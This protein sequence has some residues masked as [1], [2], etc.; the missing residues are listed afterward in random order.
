MCTDWQMCVILMSHIY[1]LV[2]VCT[3]NGIQYDIGD[4]MQPNCTTRCTC[5]EGGNFVCTPQRCLLDGPTCYA[6]GD[7][8]YGSFD[9]KGFDCQGNCEYVLT[10]PCNN[11]D[12]IITAVNTLWVVALYQEQVQ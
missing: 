6:S 10:K 8:Y 1:F 4:V 9:S 3:H 12:F 7:P 2:L 5:H 11:T